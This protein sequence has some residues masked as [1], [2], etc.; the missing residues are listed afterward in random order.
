[1]SENEI[2]QSDQP[3]PYHQACELMVS[4]PDG[5]GMV[6]SADGGASDILCQVLVSP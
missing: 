6:F 3:L 5:K 4:L 2:P 1:M